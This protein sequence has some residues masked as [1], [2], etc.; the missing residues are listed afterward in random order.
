VYVGEVTRIVLKLEGAMVLT[1]KLPNR[2]DLFRPQLGDQVR[3]SWSP[4][5]API[6][7]TSH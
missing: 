2:R 6:L 3:V 4:E 5:E 1:A 7:A